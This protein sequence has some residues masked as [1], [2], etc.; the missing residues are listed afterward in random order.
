[1]KSFRIYLLSALV[2]L[3]CSF[4]AVNAQEEESTSPFTV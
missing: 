2:A 3:L 1:M 4:S